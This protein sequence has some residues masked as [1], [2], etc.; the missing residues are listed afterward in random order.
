M[1]QILIDWLNS[2]AFSQYIMTT[3]WLWPMLEM[4]HFLGLCLMLGSLLVVD[5]RV[6]G[7]ARNVPLIHVDT[8]IR[9]TLLGFAINLASGLVFVIGDSDRYLVNIGFLSKM[10][11][12]AVAG[13]NAAYFTLRV[14]PHIKRGLEG[15]A[16]PVEARFIAAFSLTLWTCVIV[17]GRLIPY[18]E[19]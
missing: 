16:L 4:A 11:L 8:F 14:R 3:P 2:T 18:V 6:I 15:S 1:M 5:L 9:L 10:V 17:L 13:V 7:V 19:A 12:I